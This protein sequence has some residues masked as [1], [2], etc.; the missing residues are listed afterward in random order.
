MPENLQAAV[1]RVLAGS[2]DEA[3]LMTITTAIQTGQIVLA[4]GERA[5]AIN[6]DANDSVYVTGDHNHVIVIKGAEAEEIGRLLQQPSAVQT[7]SVDELVQ[8]VRFRASAKILNLFSKIR[9]LNKR[10]IEVDRLYVDVYVL[11]MREVRATIPGLLEGQDARDQFDRFGLG[12]RGERSPGLAIA[13]SEDFPRLIVLGKPGSGKS[14]FLRHLAVSCAKEEFLGDY[15]PVLLELRDVDETAFSLFQYL[16]GEF[17]LEQEAQTEQILKQGR[18]LLLL[19]GLDEVPSS[20]R[21]TVQ[22][23]LRKF[24]KRYD[25]NRFILTCRTQTTEYIPEQFQAVEVAPFK[26]EQVE[27]F[28]LNW[29][30]AMAGTQE[31]GV[32]LKN[33]FMEKLRESPQTTELAV[34]PVLLSLTCWIFDDLKCLPEKRSDLYRDGLDLLLQQWDEGR[35]ISR[36]SGSDRYHQLT[37]EERKR[38]LSYLAVR[39]FEQT[40]NFVLYEESELCGYIAEHLQLAVEESRAVLAA[41]AQ[42]HGLLIERAQGIWSFSHL[43]FQ[44]YLAAKLFVES[45]NWGKFSRYVSEEHWRSVFLLGIEMAEVNSIGLLH[46]M[47]QTIDRFAAEDER[48]QEFLAWVTEKAQSVAIPTRYNRTAVRAMYF[49]MACGK[50]YAS[51]TSNKD[52]MLRQVF[53]LAWAIDPELGTALELALEIGRSSHLYRL[54]NLVQEIEPVHSQNELCNWKF[55]DCQKGLLEKY[56]IANKLFLDCLNESYECLDSKEEQVEMMLL[57][58]AEIKK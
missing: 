25:K 50:A 33:H 10:Q 46:E 18:V 28:A 24:A 6:G 52:V 38:L 17:G 57:P 26:P 54:H 20:L 15:I 16:H 23:E 53:P 44:E 47:K 1:Q 56:Y 27:C 40:E 34:T 13:A 36:D 48:M 41:I 30:T 11:E 29:F 37:T 45:A 32:A 7:A 2:G 9:L 39:K 51:Y 21:Q 8:Q 19:D 31:Q 3:D 43:T 58:I 4:T 42:Q 49:E 12:K 5:I 35:G 55:D 22:H 14:T